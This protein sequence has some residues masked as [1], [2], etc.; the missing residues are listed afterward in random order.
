MESPEFW[1]WVWVVAAALFAL[2]EMTTAGSFFLLPFAVGALLA[3]VLAFLGAD[4]AVEWLA[5]V[6]VSA[7]SFAALR[8]LARRLDRDEPT[9]GIGS[10]RL[11]GE[12]GTVLDDI[13]GGHH[14]L[15]LARIGREEWRAESVDERPIAAGSRVRVVDVRGTRVVVHSVEAPSATLPPADRK[16]Q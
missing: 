14:E 13:P 1:R 5:F 9:D 2:G 6:A 4:V 16:E 15:G 11:I 7:G 12:H 3:A 10:R 8:P